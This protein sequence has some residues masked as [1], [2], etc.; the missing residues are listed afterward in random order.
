MTTKNALREEIAALRILLSV[1]TTERDMWRRIA[2]AEQERASLL[3]G[4]LA[5]YYTKE[6]Q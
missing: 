6:E 3:V 1:L 4:K 5:E 2:T